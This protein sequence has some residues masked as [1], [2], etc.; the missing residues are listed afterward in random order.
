MGP[1][2]CS[3]WDDPVGPQS[4]RDT[5]EHKA[6]V[7]PVS[8][9]SPSLRFPSLLHPLQ[10]ARCQPSTQNPQPGKLC[11]PRGTTE[12]AVPRLSPAPHPVLWPQVRLLPS[13]PQ[14]A[15][16]SP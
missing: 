5:W 3:P 16:T 13:V 2:P 4:T 15:A 10:T 11:L 9:A 14:A 1:W 6:S 7:P 12:Q 8:S